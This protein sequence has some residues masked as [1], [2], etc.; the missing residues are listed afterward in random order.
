M[1]GRKSEGKKAAELE[2]DAKVK[3][4]ELERKIAELEAAKKRADAYTK[5]EPKKAYKR[6]MQSML[7]RSNK[8]S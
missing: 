6:Y 5:T 2:A 4:I 8:N 1:F 7:K 3:R